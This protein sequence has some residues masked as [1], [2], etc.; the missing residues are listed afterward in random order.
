MLSAFQGRYRALETRVSRIIARC[1]VS[2]MYSRGRRSMRF[3]FVLIPL[4]AAAFASAGA[5]TTETPV[6]FDSAGRI[7]SVSRSLANRLNLAPPLW[8]AGTEFVEARAYQVS[9]GGYVITVGLANGGVARYPLSDAQFAELRTE[10]QRRMNVEGKV[11]AEDA[12]TVI[13]ESARGPFVRDQ[14]ILATII[15]GPSLAAL[16]HDASAGTGLYLLSVGGTFFA[17]NDFARR[18]TV[19][20][21]QNAMTTDGA[22]RGWA[23]T[24]LATNA[25]GADLSEDGAAITALVGGVGGSLIGYRRGSRLTHA[26][27]E[28]AMSG[29]T[30][31]AATTVGLGFATGVLGD[32]SDRAVSAAALAGGIAGYVAGPAYPRRAPYTVTAGDVSMVKLGA[33]LGAL[34]AITP[35]VT[36]DIDPKVGVGILTAGWMGGAMVADRIAAKPFNHSQGDARMIFLGSLGGGLMGM[37]LPIMTKSDNETFY[38]TAT[39]GGAVLGAFITQSAMTPARE[40]QVSKP[41]SSGSNNA[42][43][44]FSPEALAMTL[45]RQPGMHSLLR[46]RF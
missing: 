10:F 43:V 28:A 30:L 36:A 20:K 34:T 17:L 3:S 33:V 9:T 41:A 42:R 38:M 37:A 44:Q 23:A 4:A 29:S 12:A 26:E 40:G 8:P 16:T 7:S 39:T 6:P 24:A 5:Q 19:T 14:M 45:A 15:Y 13:S 11:V 31:L 22:L 18:R 35:F 25:L 21:A 2:N 46:I 32:D 1:R 27:A